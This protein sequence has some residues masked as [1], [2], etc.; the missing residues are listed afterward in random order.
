[1]P[2]YDKDLVK[3]AAEGRWPEVIAALSRVDASALDGNHHP[4]PKCGGTDRFNLSRNG[5]GG[6]HCN[7]CQPGTGDGIGTI[8][9]LNGWDFARALEAVAKHCGVAPEKAKRKADPAEHLEFLAWNPTLVGLWC[10]KKRP[11]RPE[12]IQAIGGRVARYRGQYTVIAIPVWGPSLQEADAVGWVL[13]RID[14]GELPKWSKGSPAPE[15]VKVKLTGGSLPGIIGHKPRG[16]ATNA[17]AW[18]TEG[19]SDLLALLSVAPDVDAFANANGAQ[20]KPL[21]WVV[22]LCEG[23]RVNV[24]HDADE[25]GQK[26]ATWVPLRDGQRRPGWCP[27]LATVA[28]EVRNVTLPF[29]VEPKHGPDLRDFLAGGGTMEA[30]IERAEAG[31]VFA[32]DPGQDAETF[33][34]EDEDDPQRLARVNLARYRAE[35]DGRLAYW[36][37]E[38]WKWKDGRYRKIDN[39]ELRAKVWMAIRQEFEAC[40]RERS[41]KGDD[42][43]VRKVTRA[44]VA[45]VIGAMESM[46]ALPSSVPMPCWLQDRSAPHYVATSNGILDLDAVFAGMEAADVLQ[47]HS[48]DWFSSFRLDYPFDPDADCP[49]WLEYLDYCMSGDAERIAILQEW[50]GYLLTNSNDLQKFLVLEGEGGNGKTVYFASMTAMLGSDNVSHVTLENFGGRFELGTTIGKAANIS[51]DAGEIDMVAEGVLKQFTGGDVMQFDRKNLPPVMARPTAKLMA[52]WNTRPRLRDKS[53]GVWRRMLLIP[54]DREIPP[55]R[56]VLGMDRPGWWL[57]HDEAPGILLWAIVGLHRLRSQ[58]AFSRSRVSDEAM[59]EYREDSNPV[60]E[61]FGDYLEA[62]QD[63]A[64]SSSRLYD[65]YQHWCQKSG[66]KRP[67]ECRQFGKEIKRRFPTAS[68][69]RV[70]SGG[71]LHWEYSGLRFSTDEIFSMPID[72]EQNL[73]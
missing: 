37:D 59:S 52:A 13:Y 54:F 61:F 64:I 33:V 47:D 15:W 16:D 55:D 65:L 57:E 35:H 8:Q 25:P 46:C 22:K 53:Q 6:A 2:K 70:R 44:L 34:V 18:K 30:L 48:P 31:Q 41:A 10:L 40:W 56:R 50:A 45:N 42:K 49:R 7:Q 11:I 43:P 32:Q 51:G 28:A 60:A 63:H 66:I 4:C 29:I 72:P 9:W 71:K 21:D 12:A 69:K 68:R 62:A 39:S 67:M 27:S 5:D 58:G 3:Q 36:R 14:G 38:W 20:E 17:V 24:V 1:V 26:G 73:F 23:R 19:P